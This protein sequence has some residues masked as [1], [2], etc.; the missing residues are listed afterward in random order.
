MVDLA[1]YRKKLRERAEANRKAFEGEYKDEI[2]GLLG[3]SK[4]EI[5]RITP[6]NTDL[7][8]Y[9]RLISVVKE[10][11][12]ANIAQAE[13]KKN[14]ENISELAVKI[15]KKVPRLAALFA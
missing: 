5:D 9:S 1:A 13:L 2:Q 8:T 12:A 10:A 15:A 7:E 6:D 3:L 11:S 4:T 14:I